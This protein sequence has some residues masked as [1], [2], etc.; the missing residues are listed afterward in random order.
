MQRLIYLITLMGIAAFPIASSVSSDGGSGK[1]HRKR[2]HVQ[3]AH[4]ELFDVAGDV[5]GGVL[6]KGD[7]F[8]P[9]RRAVTYLKRSHKCL[10][11]KMYTDN[12]PEGAYTN[13]WLV[14]ND[15]GSCMDSQSIPGSACGIDDL[16]NPELATFWATG[17]IVGADG[18]GRF[19][20]RHCIGD[21]RG[22]P[23]VD[24]PSGPPLP[25]LQDIQGPG[26]KNPKGGLVWVIVKYH[27]PASDDSAILYT[28]THSLLGACFEGA[29]A[30]EFPG[31]GVQC[32][33][34]QFAVFSPRNHHD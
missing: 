30:V 20:D 16:A 7:A 21:D 17:G 28:Q 6:T 5:G 22:F 10:E 14:W 29:N 9:S 23:A 34:P 25:P 24:H 27:G 31:F 26:L 4:V 12:L 8:E 18:I 15:P 1:H 11:Y 13:W 19:H 3:R 33:D 2:A 32:F